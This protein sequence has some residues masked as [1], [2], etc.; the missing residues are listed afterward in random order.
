MTREELAKSE[1]ENYYE[2]IGSDKPTYRFH[3]H[4]LDG[5]PK[6]VA[7]MWSDF[8]GMA[9]G[10]ASQLQ[11]AT[12][13]IHAVFDCEAGEYLNAG[14]DPESISAARLRDEARNAKET[15][16]RATATGSAWFISEGAREFFEGPKR[17]PEF[18]SKQQQGFERWMESREEAL[19][20]LREGNKRKLDGPEK[21][22]TW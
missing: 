2:A 6:V 9:R 22:I 18:K 17:K 14:G 20:R 11:R 13:V 21:D 19:K 15:A 12:E 7:G 3:V 16:R 1:L 10:M 5:E 8:I 4:S